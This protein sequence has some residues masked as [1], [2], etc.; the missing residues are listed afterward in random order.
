MISKQR[1]RR[2]KVKGT[3]YNE[4]ELRACLKCQNKFKALTRFNK[5]CP[6][7]SASN[8]NL[9]PKAEGCRE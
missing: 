7:C 9:S 3:A 1:N 6:G 4:D 8:R 2:S 5:I